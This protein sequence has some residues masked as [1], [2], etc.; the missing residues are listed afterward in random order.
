MSTTYSTEIPR[1]SGRLNRKLHNLK[2]PPDQLP[3]IAIGH[4]PTIGIGTTTTIGRM[5]TTA[6]T[7]TGATM[8][9]ATITTIVKETTIAAV[10]TIAET[11]TIVATTTTIETMII[12]VII[13]AT[14]SITPTDGTQEITKGTPGRK[15]YAR[16]D[17]DHPTTIVEGHA[18]Y[19]R[20]LHDPRNN[21]SDN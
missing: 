16:N 21:T 1:P 18:P 14:T 15:M 2:Q 4:G 17:G 20:T 10:I 6:M 11:T 9:I 3:G 12:V 8:T 7:T 13:I 5:T 19:G